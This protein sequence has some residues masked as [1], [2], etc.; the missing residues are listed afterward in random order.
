MLINSKKINA[1]DLVASDFGLY[2]HFSI[3][4]DRCSENGL[5]M[6]ISATKRTGTVKEEDWNT[7]TQGKHTYIVQ[8]DSVYSVEKRLTLA[9][10][11]INN[12]KYSLFSSNCENFA[13]GIMSG[14]NPASSV[15]VA[16]AITGAITTVLVVAKSSNETKTTICF[17]SLLGAAASVYLAKA[18]EKTNNAEC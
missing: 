15:Q 10:A 5:P 7:V 18:D 13:R 11:Q 12:W 1:G 16:A 9:R 17:L 3:A 14:G 4:S 8:T 2:Q 6:L